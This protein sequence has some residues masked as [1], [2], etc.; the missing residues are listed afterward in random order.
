LGRFWNSRKL[1]FLSECE[2]VQNSSPEKTGIFRRY[3]KSGAPNRG[4]QTPFWVVVSVEGENPFSENHLSTLPGRVDISVS[5]SGS[6]FVYFSCTRSTG[7]VKI[8]PTIHP[9]VNRLEV[10]LPRKTSVASTLPHTCESLSSRGTIG[11]S[12]SNA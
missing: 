7:S 8:R 2:T 6:T 10:R 1:Q 9:L 3:P 4:P 11:Q 12:V 5:S